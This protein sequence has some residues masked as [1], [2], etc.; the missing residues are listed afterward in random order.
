[1]KPKLS[2]PTRD[3]SPEAIKRREELELINELY[4]RW[5]NNNLLPE[6]DFLLLQYR[7]RLDYIKANADYIMN[8][9]REHNDWKQQEMNQTIP[10]DK[11]I[12]K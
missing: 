3:L 7:E 12:T 10:I 11:D 4:V 5:V 9:H 6:D 8:F 2:I 1:M